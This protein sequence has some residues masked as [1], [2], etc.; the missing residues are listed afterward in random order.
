MSTQRKEVLQ[1][2]CDTC[3]LYLKLQRAA[4]RNSP[5]V[6]QTASKKILSVYEYYFGLEQMA[7]FPSTLDTDTLKDAKATLK[8]LGDAPSTGDLKPAYGKLEAWFQRGMPGFTVIA[9]GTTPSTNNDH[10]IRM[11]PSNRSLRAT[12]RIKGNNLMDEDKLSVDEYGEKKSELTHACAELYF[13]L[14]ADRITVDNAQNVDFEELVAAIR[15]AGSGD[16]FLAGT[17]KAIT[18]IDALTSLRVA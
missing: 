13:Q 1:D 7:A 4:H 15:D 9:T 14:K 18:F 10:N 6:S 11:L 5:R 2:A 8:N 3:N 17:E 12:Y 16:D